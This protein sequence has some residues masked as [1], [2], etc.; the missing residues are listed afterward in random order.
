MA[1]E[2]LSQT[3]KTKFCH[4]PKHDLESLFYV[5]LTLC[6]YTTGPGALR[7]HIPATYE[8]SI[9]MNYWWYFGQDQH[10]LARHKATMVSCLDENVTSRFAPYWDDFIP[11]INDLRNVLWPSVTPVQAQKNVATHKG[12]LKVLTK[13]RDKFKHEPEASSPLEYALINKSNHPKANTARNSTQ[14][15]TTV[16]SLRKRKDVA[17][18]DDGSHR[19]QKS[20]RATGKIHFQ[21]IPHCMKLQS[22]ANYV[23]SGRPR[24]TKTVS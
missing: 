20:A 13:A 22:F 2:S 6:T 16:S 23:D 5:I 9:C 14:P 19:G 12:F 11:F 3:K 10:E 24:V 21:L 8:T 15:L 17:D 7:S 18:A 1:I 4:Q